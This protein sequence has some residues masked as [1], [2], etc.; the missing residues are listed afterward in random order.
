MLTV[1]TYTIIINRMLALF[2][3]DFLPPSTHPLIDYGVLMKLF[4]LC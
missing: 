4:C 3:Q 1:S 2:H